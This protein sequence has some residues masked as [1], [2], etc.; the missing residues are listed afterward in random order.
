MRTYP[1]KIFIS[2]FLALHQIVEIR[3][4][5]Q[6]TQKSEEARIAEIVDDRYKGQEIPV[7]GQII[8]TV[9]DFKNVQCYFP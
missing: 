4:Q 3:A 6:E 8:V 9:M 5:T 7:L 2:T 1:I